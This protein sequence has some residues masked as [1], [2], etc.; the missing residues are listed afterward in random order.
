MILLQASPAT[1]ASGVLGDEHRVPTPRRLLAVS[2]RMRRRESP[3]HEILGMQEH[4]ADAL[5]IEVGAISRSEPLSTTER[6]A[7]ERVEHVIE[8]T[9]EALVSQLAVSG[10]RVPPTSRQDSCSLPRPPHSPSR[11]QA[12]RRA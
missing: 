12:R 5:L 10:V 6:G 1:G 7:G 3:S 2:R 8:R 11:D 4:G 9:H